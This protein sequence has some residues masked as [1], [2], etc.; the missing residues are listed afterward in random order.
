[1]KRTVL[2]AL[3]VIACLLV[4]RA[5]WAQRPDGPPRNPLIGLFDANND[6]ELDKAEIEQAAEKLK[7]LDTSKDGKLSAEELRSL[8][9]GPGPGSAVPGGPGGGRGPRAEATGPYEN[10]LQAKDDEEKN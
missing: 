5:A 8:M 1:M 6:G 9:R 2:T 4:A 7:A 3:V 10:P